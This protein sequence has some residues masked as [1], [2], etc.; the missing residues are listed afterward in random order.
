M[1]Q[2]LRPLD[3]STLAKVRRIRITGRA[4]MPSLESNH[5]NP[6]HGWTPVLKKLPGL[7]LDTLTV[8]GDHIPSGRGDLADLDQL[9][10]Q[11]DGWKELYYL[12]HNSTVLELHTK[13][14]YWWRHDFHSAPR[15]SNLNSALVMHDGPTASVSIYRSIHVAENGRMISRPATREAISCRGPGPIEE[16][17]RKAAMDPHEMKKEVL[18][19]ACRGKGVDCAVKPLPSDFLDVKMVPRRNIYDVLYDWD[20]NNVD[21]YKHVDDYKWTPLH[22]HRD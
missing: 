6:Y 11:G 3:P 16:A 8:L 14:G 17:E 4:P 15:L 19:I 7:C 20:S 21:T 10:R 12:S 1:L 13:L 18:V 9:I 2:K 22:S 5:Q